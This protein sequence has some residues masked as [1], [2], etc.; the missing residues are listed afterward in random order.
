M[1]NYT[2][3]QETSIVKDAMTLTA[4]IEIGGTEL[5]KQKAKR[6][7]SKPEA[8]QREKLDVP[9]VTVQIPP[10]PK[11]DYRFTDFM[12]DNKKYIIIIVIST[13]LGMGLIG[14]IYSYYQ[15]HKKKSEIEEQL[16][17]GDEYQNAIKE[18]KKNAEMEQQKINTEIGL[19]QAEIDAKYNAELEHYNNVIIPEYEREHEAWNISQKLKI[20]MIDEEVQFNKDVLDALY[21]S[22]KLISIRYRQ[23]HILQWLY[24]ELSSS[25]V[26][27]ERAVDLYN[28]QTLTDTVRNVGN[29]VTGAINDIHLSMISG[30]NAVYDAIDSGN[31]ILAK[32]RRDQNLANTADIIQRHKLNKMIKSQNEMMN[33]MFNK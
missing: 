16:K 11:T 15:Y 8:P 26:S 10:E 2:P 9:Q 22:T 30:F 13:V 14:L 7:R 6:F 23:L 18:A 25:D 31:E 4:A 28:D 29:Q 1:S 24:N 3:E 12:K 20:K 33:Q 5:Q 32:T 17:Q 27:F 19:K 21:T